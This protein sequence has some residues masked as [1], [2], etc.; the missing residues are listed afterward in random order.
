MTRPAQHFQTHRAHGGSHFGP[1]SAF[2]LQNQA[3]R[4]L[5]LGGGRQVYEQLQRQKAANLGTRASGSAG[6]R[7]LGSAPGPFA[8]GS[9]G[10]SVVTGGSSH[11]LRAVLLL[12]AFLAAG[13]AVI[14]FLLR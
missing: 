13:M 12:A 2:S 4:R 11:L 8:G 6:R 9:G 1:A 5:W 3:N 14:L 7:S 10:S